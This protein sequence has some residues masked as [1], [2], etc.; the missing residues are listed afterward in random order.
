MPLFFAA[1][2]SIHAL[3]LCVGVCYTLFVASSI[4]AREGGV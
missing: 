4:L 2:T 3:P 1:F